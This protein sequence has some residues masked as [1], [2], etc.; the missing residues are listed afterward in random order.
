[1]SK[2]ICE[3]CIRDKRIHWYYDKS[4]EKISDDLV[5]AW[6]RHKIKELVWEK[7]VDFPCPAVETY[8]AYDWWWWNSLRKPPNDCQFNLEH[9]LEAGR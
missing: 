2:K 4:P 7:G 5:S 6:E 3:Q 8:N 9:K 1:L